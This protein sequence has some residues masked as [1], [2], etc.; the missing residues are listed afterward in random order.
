[1]DIEAFHNSFDPSNLYCA[2]E[3]IRRRRPDAVVQVIGEQAEQL[4][5][6]L[7]DDKASSAAESVKQGG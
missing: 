5:D 4:E 2:A 7:Y 6:R 1:V 3:Y